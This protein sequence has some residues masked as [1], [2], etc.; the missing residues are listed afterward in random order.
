MSHVV[1][2]PPHSHTPPHPACSTYIDARLAR[3]RVHQDQWA[4]ASPRVT[5]QVH[6]L[7]AVV[8]VDADEL[9]QE[10][11]TAQVAALLREEVRRG[12]AAEDV[13]VQE[14]HMGVGAVEL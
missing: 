14:H 13:A 10:A 11:H 12:V 3:V 7:Q 6:L 9:A 1:S 8:H 2:A 5:A 4:A